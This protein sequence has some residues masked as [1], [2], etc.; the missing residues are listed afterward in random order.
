VA[1]FVPGYEASQWYGVGA[2]KNTPVEIVDRLN[3][4]ITATLG[5]ARIQARLAGV[6]SVAMPMTPAQCRIFIA[7]ETEKWTKVVKRA[8]IRTEP[9]S[10]FEILEPST[11][12]AR[13]RPIR[14][15]V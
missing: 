9:G 1:D 11:Q 2:P 3:A 13:A 14:H 5:D 7:A 4:E 15:F 6:A 10:R 8:K 12:G